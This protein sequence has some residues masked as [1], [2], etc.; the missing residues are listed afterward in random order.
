MDSNVS[1]AQE[2]SS[3]RSLFWY[4]L[5]G[6]IIALGIFGTVKI[7]RGIKAQQKSV[8]NEVREGRPSKGSIDAP[9]LIVEYA[10]FECPYSKLEVPIVKQ[11]LGQYG[12][13]VRFEYR[14]LPIFGKHKGAT[15]AS[16]ASEC[17]FAQ[18]KFWE[19][20][21]LLYENQSQFDTASLVRYAREVGL[22]MQEFMN[23]Y[24]LGT[25]LEQIQKEYKEGVGAR[26]GGTPTF[27]VN[28][29]KIEGALSIKDWQ[30]IL[31]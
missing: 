30:R 9:I 1:I 7:A 18:G 16:I 29:S 12:G 25:P 14:H 10:D 13:K 2:N 21:D 31:K 4:V 26:I 17:A 5:I 22:N 6:I 23:C 8:I 11:M 24:S 19:Y 20:H 3:N 15:P 27:F 28:G